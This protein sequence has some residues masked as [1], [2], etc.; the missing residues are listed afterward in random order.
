MSV[1]RVFMSMISPLISASN[2]RESRQR[3]AEILV[4]ADCGAVGQRNPLTVKGPMPKSA[5]RAAE[6]GF[7]R[8]STMAKHQSDQ[9]ALSDR[10]NG[11]ARLRFG[12]GTFRVRVSV[13]PAG[14]L[15]IA[16]LVTAILLATSVVVLTAT[17]T[18]ARAAP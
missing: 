8:S 10:Q 2:H 6:A 14:L 1:V 18:R 3:Q 17:P 16:A 5:R 12:R 4:S 9:T 7:E 15:S 11:E 13:T